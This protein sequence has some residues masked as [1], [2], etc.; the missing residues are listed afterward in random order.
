MDGKTYVDGALFDNYPINLFK[1]ELNQTIGICITYEYATQY[2]CTEE[3]FVA[4]INAFLSVK[5]QK[6]Y[7]AHKNNTIIIKCSR[8]NCKIP[9]DLNININDMHELYTLGYVSCEKFINDVT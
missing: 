4:L 2:S 5:Y 6:I 8:K 9:P 7:F 3:Y 1:N